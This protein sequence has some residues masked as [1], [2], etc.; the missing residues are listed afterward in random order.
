MEFEGFRL[1]DG[2]RSERRESFEG[3][4]AG[5]HI[6]SDR[7][8]HPLQMRQTPEMVEESARDVEYPHR[9]EMAKGGQC[10]VHG[11]EVWVVPRFWQGGFKVCQVKTQC[12]KRHDV[13]GKTFA[14]VEAEGR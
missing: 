9:A 13:R 6:R 10:S 5:L 8:L 12:R 1:D 2:K 11:L 3:V 14:F 7:E 4:G